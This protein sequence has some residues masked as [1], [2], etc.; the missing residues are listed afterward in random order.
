MTSTPGLEAAAWRKSS[1]SG[2]GGDCIEVAGLTTRTAVRD[3]KNPTGP[4]LVL[5]DRAWA[6]FVAEAKRLP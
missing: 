3:S 5:S 4:A 1:Y 6:A 2:Q